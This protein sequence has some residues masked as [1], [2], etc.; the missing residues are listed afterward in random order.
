MIVTPR[1]VLRPFTADDAG[2]LLVMS[3]EPGIG[4]WM[5]DQ[6][7][8]DLAH[9]L[10]VTLALIAGSE[11]RAPRRRPCVL[12]V[13]CE[14][15]LIGHVGL[16]AFR[17]SVEIGYAIEERQQGHGYATEAVD[18]MT[19]WGLRELALPEVLGVVDRD[20]A[21][22]IRLLERTGYVLATEEP[23]R[24]VY[25]RVRDTAP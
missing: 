2:K 21:V 10:E 18:A 5:P 4:R 3:H 23:T 20:N 13:E 25:R 17:E 22:S 8:R 11:V 12:G 7:Y 24:F 15:E 1:L 9:A 16:S 19:A 14:G 6:V